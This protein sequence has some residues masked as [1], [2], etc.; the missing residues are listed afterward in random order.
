ME[1][2]SFLNRAQIRKSVHFAQSYFVMAKEALF[3]HLPVSQPSFGELQREG[4]LGT[5]PRLI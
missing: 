4:F 2:S 5:P 3:D 1:A